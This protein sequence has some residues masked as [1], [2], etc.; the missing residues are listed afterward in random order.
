[1]RTWAGFARDLV[2]RRLGGVARAKARR[3]LLGAR[4]LAIA[5]PAV[6][7]LQPSISYNGLRPTIR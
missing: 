5:R 1:L 3:R 2:V 7:V 4:R 6:T